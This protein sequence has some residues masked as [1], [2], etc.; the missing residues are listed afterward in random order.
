M[1][2]TDSIIDYISKWKSDAN[3]HANKSNSY[4]TII[5]KKYSVDEVCALPL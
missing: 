1:N 3:A 4:V 2:F 5:N